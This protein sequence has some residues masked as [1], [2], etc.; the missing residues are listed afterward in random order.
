MTPR[1]KKQENPMVTVGQFYARHSGTIQ[2]KLVAGAEGMNR[3]ISE[4][5]VNRLGLALTGFYKYFANHR[6]QLIGKSEMAFMRSLKADACRERF[7]EIF[8]KKVPCLIFARNIK[9]PSFILE[10]AE[11]YS[12]PVFCSPNITMRLV[13]T[14]TICLE[15]DFA[16]STSLHSSMVDIQGVGVLIMGESG[17]GK[18]ECVLGLIERGYSLVSDDITKIKCLEGRDLVGTSADLTRHYIEVRG[19]GIINVASIFGASSIRYKKSINLVVTLKEWAKLENV[20]RIG[21]DQ[22]HYEILQI[23]VPHVTIPVR[24]GRDLAG[25]VEVAAL[26]QKLKN[27]GHHSAHEF[28]E[29]LLKKMQTGES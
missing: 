13:N 4:G 27:I 17:I 18:S 24:S 2:L 6:I 7:R 3:R 11:R 9:P 5:S 12:V 22:D 8:Q 16:P 23:K 1:T 10:E 19:I 26:D 25:L 28:N 14:V 15:D 20:D 21:L 29:R